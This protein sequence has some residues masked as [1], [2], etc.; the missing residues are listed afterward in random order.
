MPYRNGNIVWNATAWT[1][2]MIRFLKVNFQTMT[3][4]QLSRALDLRLT[5]TRNKLSEL[6]LKRMEL[7]YWCDDQVK[8][9]KDNY[10]AMGDVAM[11]EI[12]KACW[13][14]QKG[15]KRSAVHKKRKQL[16]LFRTPKEIHK[17]ASRNS[18]KGG[19]SYTIDKNSSSKNMH[20]RW[21]AQQLAWRN[22]DLQTAILKHPEMISAGRSLIK[23][24]RVIK[25]KQKNATGKV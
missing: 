22:K 12:F 4:Q 17:I 11:M 3:N 18:S 21:I 20:P 25:Q 7:E 13:P 24:K 8:F 5:V 2:E 1:G 23:L 9:L 10:K 14:K 19:R 6:G 16:G 15:W